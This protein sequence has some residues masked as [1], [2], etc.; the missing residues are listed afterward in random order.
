MNHSDRTKGRERIL[1]KKLFVTALLF[2][3]LHLQAI[4]QQ[5]FDGSKGNHN[6]TKL[7]LMDG[8]LVETCFY[9]FGEIGDWK[10]EQILQRRMAE[11]NDS[12]IH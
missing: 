5:I 8:N 12:H 2:G 1:L 3:V 9:N 7:G 4:A 10:N 6:W 11:R